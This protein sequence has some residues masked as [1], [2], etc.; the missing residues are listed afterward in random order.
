MPSKVQALLSK[1]RRVVYIPVKT[2]NS[3]EESQQ[4]VY[5]AEDPTREKIHSIKRKSFIKLVLW[6]LFVITLTSASYVY[7]TRSLRAANR[8]PGLIPNSEAVLCG[9]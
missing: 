9:I 5:G 2:H 6:S 3:N 4:L 7:S 1:L 8:S